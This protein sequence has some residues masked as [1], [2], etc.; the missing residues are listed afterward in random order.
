MSQTRWL[1]RATRAFGPAWAL[2]W[3]RSRH[4]FRAERL[5][6]GLRLARETADE[7]AYDAFVTAWPDVQGEHFHALARECTAALRAD[8]GRALAEA[9]ATRRPNDPRVD[10]LRGRLATGA[11]AIPH[12]QRALARAERAPSNPALRTAACVALAER[13]IEARRFSV[14]ALLDLGPALRLPLLV[15]AIRHRTGYARTAL[16]D[17]LCALAQQSEGDDIATYAKAALVDLAQQ[18]ALSP[19]EW[20]R[21]ETALDAPGVSA[22]AAASQGR[23]RGPDAA[24]A[25]AALKGEAPL[26]DDLYEWALAGLAGKD[27]SPLPASFRRGLEAGLCFVERL[28]RRGEDAGPLVDALLA[29][30]LEARRGWARAASAALRAGDDARAG[31]L[32]ARGTAVGEP[33]ASRVAAEFKRRQAWRAHQAGDDAQAL[34]LLEEAAAVLRPGAPR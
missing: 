6:L 34:K 17:E 19:L 1:E 5:L 13:G 7:A 15:V 24:V 11:E 29:S 32:L 33:L 18:H 26:G 16:V 9:E 25:A 12:L 28:Y 4:E 30:G 27:V 23:L 2:D 10:Y 20:Q 31:Q 3:L 8:Q 21:L 22:L 14:E